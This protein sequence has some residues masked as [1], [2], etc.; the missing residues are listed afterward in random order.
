MKLEALSLVELK[1]LDAQVSR[2]I[3]RRTDT[4]RREFLKKMK[5]LATEHG[6]DLAEVVVGA[7]EAMPPTNGG[8]LPIKYWNPANPTKGWS[9][10][11]RKP[12][13]VIDWLEKG[14]TLEQLTRKRVG[15][16]GLR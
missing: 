8:K 13:W 10:H 1:K 9:G 7:S 4:K 14:G 16:G 12:R 11:A 5:K 15:R 6:V 2:E 3:T